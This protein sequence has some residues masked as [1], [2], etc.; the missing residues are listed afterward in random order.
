MK[1]PPARCRRPR[2]RPA[3]ACWR[4]T[5]RRGLP[6][7]PTALSKTI[8]YAESAGR[9]Y[10]YRRGKLDRPFPDKRVNGG[11]WCRPASDISIDGSSGDGTTDVGTCAI[12]CTNGIEIGT[13]VPA[14]V[15]RVGRHGRA[16][17]VPS[18]RRELLHGRRLGAMDQ[19]QHRHPRVRPAGHAQRRRA[20]Q[21][22][23]AGFALPK[24][25]RSPWRADWPQMSSLA[26]ATLFS[27]GVASYGFAVG[28]GS[29][30]ARRMPS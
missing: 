7:S 18:G 19:R 14:P 26:T 1:R 13:H 24:T 25:Q 2:V 11:G 5:S 16:V 21:R 22:P 3:S 8:M 17:F 4:T 20:D 9:P 30:S 12:N 28:S 23:V 15:L 29:A 6:T 10:L 27:I